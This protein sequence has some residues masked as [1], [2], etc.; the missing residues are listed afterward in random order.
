MTFGVFK[1]LLCA[2]ARPRHEDGRRQPLNGLGAQHSPLAD[3]QRRAAGWAWWSGATAARVHGSRHHQRQHLRA[4]EGGD[5]S[6]AD[7]DS[8]PRYL[9]VLHFLHDDK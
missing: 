7:V 6:G 3:A 1:G 4:D 5:E 9:L 2:G 8:A